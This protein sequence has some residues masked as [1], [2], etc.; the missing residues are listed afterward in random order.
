MYCPAVLRLIADSDAGPFRDLLLF[1]D[2]FGYLLREN[3][4]VQMLEER[5]DS[6]G[7]EEIFICN[8]NLEAAK[9]SLGKVFSRVA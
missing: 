3:V 9:A 2:W 7:E 4:D 8:F 1:P 5:I 6:L